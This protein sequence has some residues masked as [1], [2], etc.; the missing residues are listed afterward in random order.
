MPLAR[1]EFQRLG[2]IPPQ[3]TRLTEQMDDP[4]ARQMLGQ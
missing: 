1:D 4:F 3:K 2:H